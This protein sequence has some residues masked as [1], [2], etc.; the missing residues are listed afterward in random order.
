[1]IIPPNYPFSWL[2]SL[3]LYSFLMKYSVYFLSCCPMCAFMDHD[4]FPPPLDT[5]LRSLSHLRHYIE[6]IGNLEFLLVVYKGH[7]RNCWLGKIVQSI[8]SQD[9]L[10][11]YEA[12]TRIRRS[13]TKN[14]KKLGYNMSRIHKQNILLII[15]KYVKKFTIKQIMFNQYQASSYKNI[16]KLLSSWQLNYWC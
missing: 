11:G 6:S 13:D 12:Q 14:L 7:I 2:C 1:M 10:F 9:S 5:T 4:L 15:V 8:F 16:L 3:I